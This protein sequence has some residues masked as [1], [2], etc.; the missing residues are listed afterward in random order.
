M[1]RLRRLTREDL[2]AA[3]QSVYDRIAA[4]R[5]AVRDPFATLLH[6]PLLAERVAAL[7]EQLR[8][9]SVLP[10]ADREL[11]ILTAGREVEA[12]FQWA[13]H[14]PVALREGTRPDAIEIVRH[15]GPTAALLPREAL[16]VE[17]VRALF[18]AHRLSDEQYQRAEAEFGRRGLVEL[19]IL[20]GYYS[21]MGFALNA[22]E[23]DLPDGATSA[24]ER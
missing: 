18:R 22:F 8:F 11:A 7:G 16:I 19:V 20:A 4:S 21:M 1:A 3:E 15:R 17:T 9:H 13:D 23:I 12:L 5:G 6:H 14:E 24:F 2:D 10:G